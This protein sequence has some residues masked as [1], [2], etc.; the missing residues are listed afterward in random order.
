MPTGHR[1]LKKAIGTTRKATG[2]L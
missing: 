1:K 2:K